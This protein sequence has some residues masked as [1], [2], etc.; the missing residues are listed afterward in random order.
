M[1]K[2]KAKELTGKVETGVP[3]VKIEDFQEES[4]GLP[5]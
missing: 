3:K 1:R 2:T 4:N 5:L